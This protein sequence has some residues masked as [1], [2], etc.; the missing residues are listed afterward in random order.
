[1]ATEQSTYRATNDAYTGMLAV[2]LVA[3]IAASSL[4]I[5]AEQTPSPKISG[6]SIVVI[7]GEDAVNVIQ[8]KTAV[9]PIVSCD[10]V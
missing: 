7:E 8:Q 3:L 1:M 6:L 10:R 2:S 4:T 5:H 9:S